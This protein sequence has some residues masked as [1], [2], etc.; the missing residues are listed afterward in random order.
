MDINLLLQALLWLT[1]AS[2]VVVMGWLIR[3]NRKHALRLSDAPEPLAFPLVSVLIPAR[4]EAENLPHTLPLCLESEYPNVEILVLD[5]QSTD[6]T[7]SILSALQR[8]H[9]TKLKVLSGTPLPDGH[10]GKNWA[11]QQLAEAAQGEIL[12]F[13]DAD[14]SMGRRAVRNTVSWLQHT[15]AGVVTAIPHQRLE[16]WAECAVV[17]LVMHVATLGFVSLRH[18]FVSSKP[19]FTVANGQWLGWTRACYESVG[20]HAAVRDAIVEDMAL[21]KR[22][23]RQGFRVCPTLA[24]SQLSV[25][26]YRSFQGVWEG[27]SK[28]LYGLMNYNPAIACI[29]VCMFACSVF[30]P[31]LL[32]ILGGPFVWIV[33]AALFWTRLEL[34]WI[35]RHPLRSVLLHPV[36]TLL[37]LA[38]LFDSIVRYY[39]GS[40]VWKARTLTAPE[41]V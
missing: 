41:N 38:L 22:A 1:M 5:D 27:F 34:A 18:A 3:I 13:C 25:R 14:V 12:L 17:P 9:P 29:V 16:S 8:Q 4:N 30:L 33:C 40:L 20:G 28:N 15:G 11:C 23:K 24:F 35:A 6:A 7:P 10:N 31:W 39:R 19:R 21:C 26:M 2:F 32:A 36:G 37:L